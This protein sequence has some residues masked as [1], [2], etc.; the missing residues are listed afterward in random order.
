MSLSSSKANTNIL[1]HKEVMGEEAEKEKTSLCECHPV[2]WPGTE[3]AA[4]P[5]R[6]LIAC[7]SLET[8]PPAEQ[9][10][11]SSNWQPTQ[12]GLVGRPPLMATDEWGTSRATGVR[13]GRM[14]GLSRWGLIWPLP[15]LPLCGAAPL[16]V[17]QTNNRLSIRNDTK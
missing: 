6:F 16:S 1:Q 15:F 17:G 2:K 14:R 10:R 11:D 13:I 8:H 4:S 7:G 12:G 3:D 9:T 5:R